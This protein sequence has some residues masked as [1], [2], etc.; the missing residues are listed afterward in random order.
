MTGARRRPD[1]GGLK[2]RRL[3]EAGSGQSN[4]ERQPF[5]IPASIDR[6][7]IGVRQATI[8][9][10]RVLLLSLAAITLLQAQTASSTIADKTK[11]MIAMPGYLP[12]YYEAKTGKL[13]L[14]IPRWNEDFLYLDSLPTGVGSNDI[15]LDRGQPGN[16]RVVRFERFGPKIFL[17]Q[18]NQD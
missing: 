16:S 1:G 6:N 2:L 18:P 13:F 15:G 9:F 17:V 8:E 4:C 12:L 10:M 14:E 3:T 5:H 7:L 11:G